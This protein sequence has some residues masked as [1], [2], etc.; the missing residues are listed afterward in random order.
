MERNTRIEEELFP[1]YVLD[2]LTAEERREV[3]D[4]VAGNREARARLA[5]LSPAVADLSAAATTPITPSP[6]VKAGLLARIEAEGQVVAPQAVAPRPAAPA[7]RPAP[8][9]AQPAPVAPRRS[10]WQVFGPALA[11]LAAL[12][13]IF[14]AVVVGRYSRRVDELQGQLATLEES[15]QTLEAQ[16]D[17]LEGEN[18]TLRRELS[19]REDQLAGLLTPGAITVALGD[20]TGE[21]P[22]SHGALTIDPASGEGVLSV[23]NL[24]PLTADQTYQAWLIVDGAP[25]S[26]GTFAVDDAG[27]AHHRVSGALPG[28][29]EAVGVSLEPAGGSDQPTP[30][31]II[32]LAGFSS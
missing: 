6:A 2:A 26:A 32:L 5:Q 11:G 15:S 25:V 4:Y 3:D 21:H 10:W 31:Q 23:A 17:A 8:R 18:Q 7:P 28:A 13:L 14:S 29:F 1:F 24:P 16:L 9:R 27:A 12:V 30:D 20:L 19:S 22:E